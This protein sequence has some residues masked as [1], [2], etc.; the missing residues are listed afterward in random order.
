MLLKAVLPQTH[1]RTGW[2]LAGVASFCLAGAIVLGVIQGPR[3]HGAELA[4]DTAAPEFRSGRDL[5]FAEVFGVSAAATAP[6]PVTPSPVEAQSV[7]S[8][9]FKPAIAKVSTGATPLPPTRPREL[10]PRMRLA[11]MHQPIE[12]KLADRG[13]NR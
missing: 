11:S 2:S 4:P 5:T 10:S 9:E 12:F 7:Q 6:S 1:A 8:V 3:R 13:G